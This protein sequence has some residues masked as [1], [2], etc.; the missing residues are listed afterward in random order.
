MTKASVHDVPDCE[1]LYNEAIFLAE[2]IQKNHLRLLEGVRR[3][4]NNLS[5]MALPGSGL[6]TLRVFRDNY[7]NKYLDSAYF[8]TQKPLVP[9]GLQPRLAKNNE[10]GRYGG[11]VHGGWETS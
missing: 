7:P 11:H 6:R 8:V 3:S 4:Y 2:A 5:Q 10:R 9:M 1:I